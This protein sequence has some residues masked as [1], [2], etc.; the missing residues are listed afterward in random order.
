MLV[1]IINTTDRSGGA[2]IAAFR[3]SQ[4]LKNQGVL[5]PLFCR[6]RKFTDPETFRYQVRASENSRTLNEY[7]LALQKIQKK[8]ITDN[9]TIITKTIFSEPWANGI[10]LGDNPLIVESKI[11]HLHWVNHFMDLQSLSELAALN[12]PIVWT[13]HDE[14]LY[15][16]GCH[17]TS[18]CRKYEDECIE[19]PQLLNDPYQLSQQWF[20]EKKALFDSLNLTIV[21][22]SKWLADQAKKSK[23]L[24]NKEIKVIRNPINTNIFT[25]FSIEKK[26]EI[27]KN[28][29]FDNE[30]LILGF[31][32]ASLKD[33][34]KGYNL[35]V[36]ALKKIIVNQDI[37]AHHK[38]GLLVFGSQ[39]EQISE[40]SSH[41]QMV[42]V[43]NLTVEAE[44][45]N[46]LNALDIF[47]VPSLEE[48]YP[49]IIM[50][51]LLCKTPV[52]GYAAGGMV[53]QIKDRDNGLLVNEV[54]SIEQLSDAIQT[55]ILD[56]DLQT[57]LK[58]FDRNKIADLH[59]YD[60]LAEEMITLYR[61]LNPNFDDS[62]TEGITDF[63]QFKKTERGLKR[64]FLGLPSYR[65][66]NDNINSIKLIES[67]IQQISAYNTLLNENKNNLKYNGFLDST[68]IF[69]RNNNT[70]RFLN[71]GWSPAE[72][73]GTWSFE[74][75]SGLAFY[76]PDY[77]QTVKLTIKAKCFGVSQIVIIHFCNKEIHRI[78]L[79]NQ[80]TISVLK[81]KIP[82][83]A[84]F[85]GIKQLNFSFPHAQKEK[86][87]TRLLGM[88]LI[89]IKTAV[90]EE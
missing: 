2:G 1:S 32:A 48:N 38:V 50:E 73:A 70:N 76:S 43:G 71:F 13:L 6:H 45:A 22:P 42:F 90:L 80:L 85:D 53:E 3:L 5:S 36:E 20:N 49:N 51:S 88:Y 82:E 24:K 89:E 30:T 79:S 41:I 28:F 65:V 77:I 21:T 15:T 84:R 17:Y 69:N 75:T 7:K 34:R 19:C 67:E 27:R 78:K 54:G 25:P 33:I 55:F 11:I 8:F 23:L 16:A 47:I 72:L 63:Y 60:N 52:I 57:K 12:I 37:M 29:G 9:R 44:I 86:G 18:G 39:S 58:N 10:L 61:Q 83:S 62:I 64:D 14:W 46:V 4:A 66:T 40:L 56:T 59:S 35:L 26:A 87:G 31:G 74:K 81:I 68:H